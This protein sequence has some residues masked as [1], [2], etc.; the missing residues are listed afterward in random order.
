MSAADRLAEA[1]RAQIASSEGM[2]L[3]ELID[4]LAAYDA[5]RHS[6]FEVGF[7]VGRA[8]GEHEARA[9]I[10]ELRRDA[11]RDVIEAAD[12]WV[13][14]WNRPDWPK[15][16]GAANGALCAAVRRLQEVTGQ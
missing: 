15:C 6:G 7:D 13:E 5:D 9:V 14:A 4:A 1:A 3:V 10:D 16:M 2:S 8:H 11:E 12:E